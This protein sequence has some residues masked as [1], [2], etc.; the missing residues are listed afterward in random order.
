M[1]HMLCNFLFVQRLSAEKVFQFAK[2]PRK[3]DP[4]DFGTSPRS[5]ESG[6]HSA[7]D[8]RGWHR[9]GAT[10]SA[11]ML[12]HHA[13]QDLAQELFLVYRRAAKAQ[14]PLGFASRHVDV[15]VAITQKCCARM[16]PHACA[17]PRAPRL[18]PVV[19]LALLALIGG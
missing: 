1:W 8:P 18:T 11:C 12:E 5:C 17:C 6:E 7:L 10:C 13:Q 4:A 15:L 16:R 9:H 3:D 14:R 2:V 19:G